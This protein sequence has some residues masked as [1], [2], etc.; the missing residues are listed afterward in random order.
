[1]AT[2]LELLGAEERR[3]QFGHRR[4]AG[5]QSLDHFVGFRLAAEYVAIGE[6]DL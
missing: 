3:P 1:M 5:G 4:A 2:L 6:F